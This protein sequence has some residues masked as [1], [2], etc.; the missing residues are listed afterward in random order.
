M[1]LLNLPN[2]VYAW[3]VLALPLIAYI[4][5]IVLHRLMEGSI[6]EYIKTGRVSKDHYLIMSFIEMLLFFGGVGV[7]VMLNG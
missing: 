2:Y 3:C 1:S 5:W 4:D 7:G 6:D